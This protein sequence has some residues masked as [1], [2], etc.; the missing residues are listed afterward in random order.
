ML[1]VYRLSSILKEFILTRNKTFGN[2]ANSRSVEDKTLNS[3]SQLKFMISQL[4]TCRYPEQVTE[5]LKTYF[6]ESSKFH[7]TTK[8]TWF[9]LPVFMQYVSC[10]LWF[11]LFTILVCTPILYSLPLKIIHGCHHFLLMQNI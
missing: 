8:V 7:I 6:E 11:S 1:A 2:K 9:N 5:L 10:S 4:L 3:K